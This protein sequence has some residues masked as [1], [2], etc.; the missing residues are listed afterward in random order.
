MIFLGCILFAFSFTACSTTSARVG[1][2]G[3]DVSAGIEIGHDSRY[4]SHKDSG[5][6]HKKGPPAH[7]PAHGYRAKHKYHYYPDDYV[8]FDT[9]RGLYFYLDGGNWKVSASL[10]VNLSVRLGDHVTISMDTDRPYEHS[11]K[12]KKNKNW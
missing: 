8:Y 4:D 2:G 11:H 7:A 1:V 9:G 6:H 5:R 3:H 12:H 10:P